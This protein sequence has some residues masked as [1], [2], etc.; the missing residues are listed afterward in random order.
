MQ[1]QR[2]RIL[3][4]ANQLSEE[5]ARRDELLALISQLRQVTTDMLI[6]QDAM[7]SVVRI[8]AARYRKELS[9]HEQR[10]AE[11]RAV[12]GE[13]RRTISQTQKD[14]LEKGRKMNAIVEKFLEYPRKITYA[15]VRPY[16]VLAAARHGC[17]VLARMLRGA[18]PALTAEIEAI[19]E[20]KADTKEE[21]TIK[22]AYIKD[23]EAQL[24][25][26]QQANKFHEN[27]LLAS[28]AVIKELK[29]EQDL[30]LR[31]SLG[32]TKELSRTK[33]EHLREN[34]LLKL[35]IEELE[36]ELQQYRGGPDGALRSHEQN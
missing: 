23:L 17:W 3:Q 36:L 29:A 8:L 12:I 22:T 34:A 2:T 15:W 16:A 33:S 13:I 11:I 32:F 25:E 26:A 24:L 35:R 10:E 5:A 9:D 19:G 20:M 28:D 27:Q 31:T 14:V 7:K 30:H 21:L 1:S 18:R 6:Q 4:Q